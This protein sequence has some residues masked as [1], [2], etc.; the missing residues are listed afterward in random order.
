MNTSKFCADV[1]DYRTWP[2]LTHLV[3]AIAALCG[4][5]TLV[6]AQIVADP[7]AGSR[8]PAVT[9]APNGVPLVNITAP[10]SGLSHNQFSTLNV[11][12]PGVVLNNSPTSVSTSIAGFVPGNANLTPG[13]SAQIILNEV[14]GTGRSQ[15]NG[16]VE[17][18]GQRAAVIFANPNGVSINGLGFLNTSRAVVT[19]GVPVMNSDG[20]LNGL[21]V[22]RGDI[23]IGPNGLNGAGLDQLD[24]IARSIAVNGQ[25][26]TSNGLNLVTGSNLVNYTDLGVTVIAGDGGKPTVAIDASNLGGMFA[27]RIRLIGTEAGVGVTS[28]GNIAASAGDI[29]IDSKGVVTNLGRTT[30]TGHVNIAAGDGLI[31]SGTIYAQTNAQMSS[32][33]QI[34]NTGT[35]AAQGEL[36]LAAGTLNSTGSLGAGIDANSRATQAGNLSVTAVDTLSA[37]GQNTA[38][39]NISISGGSVNLAQAQTNAGG[40]IAV[41]AQSGNIDQTKGTLQA[42]GSAT[43]IATGNV[44]NDQGSI[45]ATSLDIKAGGLS[46]T[47]GSIAQS[48]NGDTS[49]VTSGSLNNAGTIATN[50]TNLSIQS[51]SLINDHGQ[52]NHAGSGKQSI[53]TGTFSNVQG[54]IAS[55]GAAS[56]QTAAA[57]NGGSITAQKTLDLRSSSLNNNNGTL[58]SNGAMTVNVDAR[59]SNNGGSIQ[60]GTTAAP[61]SATVDAANLDNSSGTLAAGT[62]NLTATDLANSG[63]KIIQNDANGAATISVLRQLNNAQGIIASVASNLSVMAG[64]FNNDSGKL[65][66]TGN[67]ALLIQGG[68]VSNNGGAI[69]TNG[70]ATITANTGS[71]NNV[72]GAVSALGEL[73]VGTSA[74]LDNS[75]GSIKALGNVAVNA[76][77]AFANVGGKIESLAS[78]GQL[79]VSGRTI[80]NTNGKIIN[81]GNGQTTVTGTSSILNANPSAVSGAGLIGGAGDVTIDAPILSNR[82]GGQIIAGRAMNLNTTS[83]VNNSGGQMMATNALTLMQTGATLTNIGGG[84]SAGSLTLSSRNIDNTN[85]SIANSAGNGDIAITT[86]TLTNSG[87][88][89][90]SGQDLQLTANTVNGNGKIIAGRDANVSM[91]GDY[92]YRSGNQITANRNLTLST[93]GTLNNSGTLA[94]T[95]NLAINAAGV[96]NAAGATIAS[97]HP[98][99]TTTGT[100]TINAGAGV[101]ANAGR[102]EGNNVTINSAQLVN[103]GTM[104]GNTV[105]VSASNLTNDGTAAIIAGANQVNLWVT[106]SLN[107][108]N[109]AN[110]YSLGNLNIAASAAKD[111]NGY[112]FRQ[113]GTLNNLSSTIEADGVLNVAANQIN[114]IRQNVTTDTVTVA[115][116][117]STMV[118]SSWW[119]SRAPANTTMHDAYFVDPSSIVSVTP[120]VT[121]DGYLIYKAVVNFSGNDSAFQIMTSGLSYPLPNG[122][123]DIQYMKQSRVTVSP[124]QQVVYFTSR[125]DNQVN[126]DQVA[127]NVA[128]PSYSN[129][130]FRNVLGEITY[131]SQYGNCSTNCTRLAMIPDY[132][133]PTR[134]FQN[135]T[136]IRRASFSGSY[137]VEVQRIAHQVVTATQLSPNSGAPAL[138]T[139]GGDMHMAIGTQLNNDKGNIAAGGNLTI[140]GVA[141]SDGSNSAK[142]LNTGTQLT[143]TYTS[144]IQ[145][146]FGTA[147]RLPAPPVEWISWSN[148]PITLATGVVGG[149]I[150]S[151]QAVSISGGQINNT[152]V[153][154]AT[155]P[156]GASG[157][158]LGL[159]EGLVPLSLSGNG[160]IGNVAGMTPG[161]ARSVN[162]VRAGAVNTVLP[163]NGLYH[164]NPQPGKS[165][166]IETDPRFTQYGNF[167]SSDYMLNLMGVNPS[168]TQKR[169][170]DGF[171]EAKLVTDQVTN[172][173]GQRYLAGYSNAEDEYKSLMTS[174]VAFAKQFNLTPGV[175]L[176]DSQMA[177][178]T[179]DM[180]WLVNQTI[181]LP[182]G[183]QQTVLVPQVYLAKNM[184]LTP[185]GAVIA[186]ESVSVKG[187]DIANN[188]ASFSAT[189]QLSLAADRDISNV[190]GSLS[191]MNIDLSAGNNIIN[192]SLTNTAVSNFGNSI[193]TVTAVGAVGKIAA[194]QN[195]TLSA[196]QNVILQAA[197][198]NAAGNAKIKA[199]NAISVE[200]VMAGSQYVLPGGNTDTSLQSTRVVGSNLVAG[201]NLTLQSGGDINVRASNLS[202]GQNMLVAAGGNV[203]IANA[204]D[205][206]TYHSAGSSKNGRETADR[207][208]ET[209]IGSTLIAGANATVLAGARLDSNG[210]LTLDTTSAD[211]AAHADSL[212]VQGS[213]VSAGNNAGGQGNVL[214]GASGDVSIV[215]SHRNNFSTIDDAS[216]SKSWLSS[217]SS[218]TNSSFNADMSTGSTVAGNAIKL[219]SGGD[220]GV[221]GSV[222]AG[223]G[224]VTLNARNNVV[225]AAAQNTVV[226]H[227]EHE[228]KK[229]GIFGTGGIGIMIG[230]KSSKQTADG[231]QL[232]QSDARSTVGSSAGNL[233]ISAGKDVLVSGS[234]LIAGKA[235]DDSTSKTGNIDILARNITIN[236]GLDIEHKTVTQESKQSGVGVALVGTPLDTVRNLQ[237]IGHN[238]GSK[239]QKAKAGLDELGF[240]A[241]T[242]PQI[243][244]TVGSSSSNMRSTVDSTTNTGSSLLAAGNIGL[245]AIGDGT[246]DANGR[247]NNGNI[248]ISGSAVSGVGSVQLEAQRDITIQSATDRYAETSQ[249]SA[250]SSSL[251]LA[252]PSAGDILRNVSGGPN[253]SGVGLSPYNAS[254]TSD[255]SNTQSTGQVASSVSGNTISLISRTGDITVAGSSIA[256]KDDVTLNAQLGQITIE[257]GQNDQTHHEDHS[258]HVVGNL[259]SGS[260][261]T[262]T[263]VGVSNSNS[264]SDSAQ[265]LQNVV[266][267]QIFS[268]SGN[269]TLTAKQ[270]ITVKGSDLSAGN[271]LILIGQNLNLDPGRDSS[272][273]Q[274]TQHSSQYGTTVSVGGMAGQL[275]QAINQGLASQAAG[276]NRVAALNAAKAGLIAANAANSIATPSGPTPALVKVTVSIGGGTSDSKSE[277]QATAN[278]GSTLSAGKDVML[279]ATGSGSK[280]AA[281]FAS[282]GDINARGTQIS[283]QNVTLAAARDI[284]LESA[285]DTTINRSNNESSNT[286]VGVG[287]ALGG[288]QNGFTLELAAAKAYGNS[289]GQSVTNQNTVITGTQTTTLASG[290]DVS[291]LGAQVR[292]TTV[293]ATVGRDLNIRSQQDTSSYQSAQNS[294]GVN[295][296]LCIPPFCYGAMVQGSVSSDSQNISSTFASVKQQSGIIAG[297]GGYNVKVNGNTD[298]VG[299]LIAS[300]ADKAKN[301]L[302]TGT[303]TVSDVKN[304]AQYS[305]DSSHVGASLDTNAGAIGNLLNNAVDN[306]AGNSQNPIKG[307]AAGTTKSAISEGN[308][309]ITDQAGQLAKTGQTADQIIASISR[310]TAAANGSISQIFDLAKV[311]R[312]QQIDQLTSQL[313][314]QAAPYLY[315]QVGD[316]LQGDSTPTKVLVHG[317][318]GGLMAK[319]IGGNF[320]AGAAGAA[321]AKLALEA[322]GEQLGSIGDM[323]P[324]EKSALIQLVG[325]TVG[326]AVA[327]FSAGSGADGN[328]AGVTAKLATQFNYL[329]HTQAAQFRQKLDSCESR[330]GGCPEDERKA[331]IAQY[332]ALSA[333]NIETLNFCAMRA[334]AACL[335]QIKESI[336]SPSEMPL[337]LVG[338]EATAFRG[339]QTRADSQVSNALNNVATIQKGRDLVC[340]AM[341]AADCDAKILKTHG[342]AGMRAMG[343][344]LSTIGGGVASS[345]EAIGI[346]SSG[347]QAL[348]NAGK[349]AGTELVSFFRLGPIVY[350]SINP[351]TCVATVDV[352]AQSTLGTA[353]PSPVLN[354]PVATSS[355]IATAKAEAAAADTAADIASALKNQS[356][357]NL[358]GTTSGSANSARNQYYGNG[359]SASPSP[360]TNTAGSSG[361]NVQLGDTPSVAGPSQFTQDYLAGSGGRWGTQATRQLNYDVGQTLE[362]SG[363][364]KVIGGG[365]ITSEEYI[366]G[367][368]PGTTGGSYVDITAKPVDGVGPTVRVQTVTTL[369][370]GITPTPS[371]AAAAA[372]ISNAYPSDILVLIPKGSTPDLVR[373]AIEQAFLK[374]GL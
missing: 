77:G 374:A 138:I 167:V 27:N 95:G 251:N 99:D 195:L 358:S 114:N 204:I 126:P 185:T 243:A 169:L 245:T 369:A 23:Q 137:P 352:A 242:T 327:Q 244:L 155:L 325:L 371:E 139:S 178:L 281:G 279:V 221:Q 108:Q 254:K 372:R 115:D 319:A 309:S 241:L 273:S 366:P 165:Y 331:L 264:T 211:P 46:N 90:G 224:N 47:G 301:N 200:T 324:Q 289:N 81:V 111:A 335:A 323:T 129:F 64:T 338:G 218:H 291:L 37:T 2:R 133:D 176:S 278:T 365:G 31:N 346:V 177:A 109:G 18:A 92:N 96:N 246:K 269:V 48:G 182:D 373:Q 311:Q 50:A 359:S 78:T 34:S 43:L 158:S 272:Q 148:T 26:Q 53:Q 15:L 100:T 170:G 173:T 329:N 94:A 62:I 59:L 38:G 363:K 351:G 222:I 234:D 55:N 162:G 28:M 280:D 36:S 271:N 261:G 136:Q 253:S 247:A 181:T 191:A 313:A 183:S 348:V 317:L 22:T 172:L 134:T 121:P 82:Q 35:M 39:G 193:S 145:S 210:N 258:A 89:I 63:G 203:N 41:A 213:T 293:N 228:E 127:G 186:G 238:G 303:L 240:S 57:I 215:E 229:S 65:A 44:I 97:G 217:S 125:A 98:G 12:A 265:Q 262:S 142:I 19:T 290:R 250:K 231:N 334:D 255:N 263:T 168:V 144:T 208:L 58:A 360:G 368:G 340:G 214:L 131:S 21:R 66:H 152:S 305:A 20:S 124:G 347:L 286:S 197:Q 147:D 298:L 14:T 157:A 342:D 25:L 104:I 235:A 266:R 154:T 239:G 83:S 364:Y 5:I 321:A 304:V 116:T 156:V 357:K 337:G 54:S 130:I 93:T 163:T 294:S 223:T 113:T 8:K 51:G 75:D 282:D 288:Q 283:G 260:N 128:W 209:N 220:L 112:L 188:G 166:L 354:L 179:S 160:G 79:Q 103:T 107:N 120:F 345:A 194:T 7:N 70:A 236:T 302:T 67:G 72:A 362:K 276:D 299:G 212:V 187:T 336:A 332:R 316:F 88:A 312:Q 122:A 119:S 164:I 339:E 40:K 30:A 367:P 306:A 106:N 184:N 252:T 32:N 86:G 1:N 49:I 42:S 117:T 118:Q 295:M 73:T 161:V 259:G 143:Q 150:S 140:D 310:D 69:G 308:I 226:T 33:G 219:T 10:V 60:A 151:N 232:T 61:T 287:F 370:N 146:G 206:T 350:C 196:G 341:S 349:V 153:G 343:I 52:I 292:G 356:A 207:H 24:L 71:F 45:S 202:S 132:T 275:T 198:V 201:G 322:F 284:N 123:G 175:A 87:G 84:L 101:L 13:R 277:S 353:A 230:S 141:S 68:A 216:Q 237:A 29:D 326:K 300:S 189:K 318:V 285:K 174:G 296:S 159:G 274:Q 180:V 135:D 248:V 171:Y 328:A 256:A 56:I 11:G 192:Q 267:S 4:G 333:A 315:K 270:D 355:E 3:L 361:S 268:S 314:Q 74:M 16:T 110:L 80:D 233:S 344:V 149:T 102:I 9:S 249:A 105:T 297:D 227:Y 6:S 76:Q 307:S 205:T 225:V 85:G 199:G 17:I 257:A 190:G 330:S 320:G 91:Q